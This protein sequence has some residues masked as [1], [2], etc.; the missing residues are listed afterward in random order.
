MGVMHNEKGRNFGLE[1]QSSPTKSRDERFPV[2]G[3]SGSGPPLEHG[4]KP[5]GSGT[6]LFHCTGK[7]IVEAE[8]P[9][10]VGDR[11]VKDS[12]RL[13]WRSENDRKKA[14]ARNFFQDLPIRKPNWTKIRDFPQTGLAL[15]E[16]SQ[17]NP[18]E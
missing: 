17:K 4:K 6:R 3:L 5:S 16:V 15:Y 7:H 8:N 12:H 18:T 13:A 14:G 2:S 10:P 9:K 1:K 11:T